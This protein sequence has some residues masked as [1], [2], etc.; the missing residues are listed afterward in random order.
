MEYWCIY[1][2][3]MLT[4]EPVDEDGDVV[5]VHDEVPHPVDATYDEEERPQ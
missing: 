1:C 4:G 2:G 3:R 5:F